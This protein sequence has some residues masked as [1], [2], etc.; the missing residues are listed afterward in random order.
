M[1]VIQVYTDAWRGT[2]WVRS[3]IKWW[4]RLAD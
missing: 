3:V 4:D 1:I 2:L